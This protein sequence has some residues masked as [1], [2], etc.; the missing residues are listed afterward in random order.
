MKETFIQQQANE[1]PAFGCSFAY[2]GVQIQC[3]DTVRIIAPS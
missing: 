1:H 3:A 2:V